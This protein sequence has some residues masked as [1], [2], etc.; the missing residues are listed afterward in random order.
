MDRGLGLILGKESRCEIFA[1]ALRMHPILLDL[2][3]GCDIICSTGFLKRG[4]E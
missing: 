3:S 4:T 1:A 2:C